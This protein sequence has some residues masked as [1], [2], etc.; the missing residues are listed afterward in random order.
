MNMSKS[1]IIGIMALI[2]FAMGTLLV[3]DVAAGERGKIMTREVLYATAVQ[4]LKVPDVDG[5]AIYLIEA[6]GIGF[7]EKWGSYLVY[8]TCTN[9]LIKGEGPVQG[10]SQFTYP[11]GSTI[12]EKWEGKNKGGGRAT[13]GSASGEGTATYIKG[14]G[15]F[16]GIQG[17]ATWK[18]YNM[19]PGQFYSDDE[20]E[21]TLP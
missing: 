12:T 7:S 18:S 10:Y 4:T 20:G 21:Y 11:D 3:E 14:T 17:E 15:K 13:T 16:E 1:K 9:D 2:V 8:L 6:K 19:G 5:H